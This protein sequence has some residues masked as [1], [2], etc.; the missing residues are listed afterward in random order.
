MKKHRIV[1]VIGTRP[2]ALK[3]IP[4]I[5]MIQQQSELSL[6]IAIT[7]QHRELLSQILLDEGITQFTDFGVMSPNQTLNALSARLLHCFN[8]YLLNNPCDLVIAQGDT[9]T[10]LIAAMAAFH[11]R[12]AFAHVE[13]GLRTATLNSPFPEEFN[14]RVVTLAAALHFCPTATAAANL[15]REGINQHVHVTGNTIIDMVS[16]YANDA[17]RPC[18]DKK[19]IL[20]TCHRRE[21]FGRP[22]QRICDALK[23]LVRRNPG[24][25][26]ILPV[27]PN[28]NVKGVIEARLKDTLNITLSPPLPY[29]ELINTLQQSWLVLTDSGGIQE[30][31]PAL[32]KPV[33][34]LRQETERPEAV[35]CGASRLVGTQTQV[36]VDEVEN[37]LENTADYAAMANAGSPYG[38]G[39]AA[40]RIVDIILHYLN[41]K[42]RMNPRAHIKPVQVL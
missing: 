4:V 15:K 31:A 36:I 2:E 37:L 28:P 34:V 32:N 9:T 39:H 40:R 27:H 25:E 6:N 5:R 35:A 22:M 20:V 33:L 12:I 19:M 7:G 24:L 16:H 26:I 42:K 1:C 21:N 17:V 11:Q 14:R 23:A 13:A 8:D 30:E 10:T 18:Q 29:K 41:S 3:M 38:D